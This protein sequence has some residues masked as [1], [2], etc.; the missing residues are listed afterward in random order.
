MEV[1]RKGLLEDDEDDK[2][3]IFG[4][5][6]VMHD[7]IDNGPLLRCVHGGSHVGKLVNI[8]RACEDRNIGCG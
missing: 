8:E 2:A 6:D 7:M 4:A 3:D 1:G 5:L